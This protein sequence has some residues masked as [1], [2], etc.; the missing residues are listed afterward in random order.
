MGQVAADVVDREVLFAKGD[1]TV[2]EGIG[3]GAAWGP[4]A[5]VR[6]KSRR[7]CWRNWWTR[8]RKLPGV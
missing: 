8:T 1:D 7:G 3:F 6:K 5:G 2:A 4:L